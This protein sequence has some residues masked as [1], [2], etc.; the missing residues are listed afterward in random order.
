MVVTVNAFRLTEAG[1]AAGLMAGRTGSTD[2]T[3]GKTVGAEPISIDML[4]FAATVS[5]G[6]VDLVDS[7]WDVV[8]KEALFVIVAGV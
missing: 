6:L 8:S 1:G 4:T 2:S 5:F 7:V 3:G